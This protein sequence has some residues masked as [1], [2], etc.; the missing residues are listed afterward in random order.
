VNRIVKKK[1]FNW[2][3]EKHY[4]SENWIQFQKSETKKFTKYLNLEKK[5]VSV[6][7]PTL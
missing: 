1:T 4:E 3:I 6:F 7:S 5:N 2:I